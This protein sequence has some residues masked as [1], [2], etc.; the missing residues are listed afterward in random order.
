MIIKIPKGKVKLIKVGAVAAFIG[1]LVGILGTLFVSN[2]N[3]PDDE[4]SF[5]NAS[6]VFGRIQSQNELVSVSQ[7]YSIT[8]KASDANTFFDLFDIPFTETAS[9]TA[10]AG[11]SRRE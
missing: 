4:P 9:G 5:E 8:D 1:L 10:I 3:L 11:P 7:G 6:I 2:Y